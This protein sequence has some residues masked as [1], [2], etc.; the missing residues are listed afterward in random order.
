MPLFV[1]VW[2]AW[3]GVPGIQAQDAALAEL[4]PSQPL[5]EDLRDQWV[6]VSGRGVVAVVFGDPEAAIDPSILRVRVPGRLASSLCVSVRSRDG[7]Y[8][9]EARYDLGNVNPGLYRLKFSTK[10]ASKLRAYKA[11]DLAALVEI[12]TACQDSVDP[13]ATLAAT[14]SAD[15]TASEVRVFLLNPPQTDAALIGVKDGRMY[16]TCSALDGAYFNGQ[17]DVKVPPATALDLVVRRH[18]YENQLMDIALA[19]R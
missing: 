13:V 10:Y 19:L 17:C 12:K 14:W 5:V 16:S 11:K 9:G 1:L 15:G 7:R 6:P 8:A 3:A 18:Y 4:V 2:P